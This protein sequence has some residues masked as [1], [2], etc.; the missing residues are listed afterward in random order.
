MGTKRV[1]IEESLG[2][3]IKLEKGTSEVESQH[4]VGLDFVI[5]NHLHFDQKY[6]SKQLLYS[7][8]CSW[9]RQFYLNK[10]WKS[11]I[12]NRTYLMTGEKDNNQVSIQHKANIRTFQWAM[13]LWQTKSVL[14][15]RENGIH[16]NLVQVSRA[17][18]LIKRHSVEMWMR[19]SQSREAAKEQVGTWERP[20]GKM[21]VV[22]KGQK[23]S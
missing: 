9:L 3:G 11:S 14:C 16:P 18:C 21:L 20:S 23:E 8:L 5:L 12:I 6:F 13:G 22:F 2:S 10:I 7:G 19:R 17:L 4:C 1:S 15:G